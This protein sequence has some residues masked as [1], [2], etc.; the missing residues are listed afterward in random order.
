MLTIISSEP[1]VFKLIKILFF[2]CGY[3]RLEEAM[4]MSLHLSICQLQHMAPNYLDVNH[5]G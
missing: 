3:R 4:Q 2:L 1:I 5:T